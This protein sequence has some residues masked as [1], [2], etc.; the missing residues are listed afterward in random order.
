MAESDG[1][2]GVDEVPE[3]GEAVAGEA[4]AEAGRDFQAV[5]CASVPDGEQ[6]VR[7]V[8]RTVAAAVE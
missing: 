7:T 6:L 3:P 2:G 8:I 4:G 1:D 5:A